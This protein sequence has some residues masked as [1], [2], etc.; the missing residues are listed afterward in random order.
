MIHDNISWSY[1]DLPEAFSG[2]CW[3]PLIDFPVMAALSGEAETTC[4]VNVI[5]MGPGRHSAT[6]L[7][8]TF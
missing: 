5:R 7:R 1:Y 6:S 4:R 2:F 3:Q 8:V